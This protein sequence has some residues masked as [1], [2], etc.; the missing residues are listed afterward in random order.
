MKRPLIVG[1]TA[2][3]AVV[4]AAVAGSVMS[5]QTTES[6]ASPEA[7]RRDAFEVWIADQSDTR[8][9]F[10]G[11]LLIFDGD[12][13]MGPRSAKATAAARLDLGAETADLCRAATGRNPVRPHMILFNEEHTHAILSFVASGHVVVL[14]A[15]T[16][17]PLSCFETTVSETTGTR[18]A[19]AAFPAPDGS[20]IL[21]AN[22]NGKRLE[23][24]D[25]DFS[26]NTFVH[27]PAA[28]LDL[29]TCV[30]PSGQPCEHPDVRPIMVLPG[31]SSDPIAFD[32]RPVAARM[33]DLRT[34]L[35]EW[36]MSESAFAGRVTSNL[37]PTPPNF[38]RIVELNEAGDVPA[39]DPTVLEAGA[40]RCAVR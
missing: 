27:N 6:A 5:A 21:V 8:P 17:T 24:I 30:A 31:H 3:G 36:L 20:Y 23:R 26:T 4:V 12:D 22:Q 1:A 2:L 39:G 18:Q 29:A 19:H 7:T 33:G 14:D 28:T 11:Q 32:G 25:T 9:G 37:P 13:V 34:W 15:E 10:G 40:N 38:V 35:A 16:R